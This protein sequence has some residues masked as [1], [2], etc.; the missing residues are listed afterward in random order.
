MSGR[1]CEKSCDQKCDLFL[2]G[3]FF[4]IENAESREDL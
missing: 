2:F 1:N 3:M 4:L